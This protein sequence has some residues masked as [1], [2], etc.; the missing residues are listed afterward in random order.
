MSS[1]TFAGLNPAADAK[2]WN[3]ASEDGREIT[4][5]DPIPVVNYTASQV[6]LL[7]AAKQIAESVKYHAVASGAE[8]VVSYPEPWDDV[9][10]TEYRVPS[11]IRIE[12]GATPK[13]S[14]DRIL[15]KLFPEGAP[16]E[17][18]KVLYIPLQHR[19]IVQ[20]RQQRQFDMIWEGIQRALY[21]ADST[22]G[23]TG[24]SG[25]RKTKH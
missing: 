4:K 5:N 2:Y 10:T 18:W 13:E 14:G 8:I 23:N 15:Q 3:T 22:S 6:S 11:I 20:A 12:R 1:H 7:D 16:P 17:P 19:L 25:S 9:A 21:A 24:E